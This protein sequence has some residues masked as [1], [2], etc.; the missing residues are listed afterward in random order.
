MY[1][2]LF[3]R[4]NVWS[5]HLLTERTDG[6]ILESAAKDVEKEQL[7]PQ[8]SLWSDHYS[9]WPFEIALLNAD[10]FFLKIISS[11]KKY[12]KACDRN[13]TG[14]QGFL[15]CNNFKSNFQYVMKGAVTPVI[16]PVAKAES[17]SSLF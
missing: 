11:A 1:G 6:I 10:K 14:V 15:F 17:Y 5:D 12:L 8:E 13:A 3:C 16:L 2:T 9:K 7:S 4:T